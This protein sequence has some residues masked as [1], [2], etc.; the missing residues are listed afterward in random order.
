MLGF[1]LLGQ[2]QEQTRIFRW[3]WLARTA[4]R[5]HKRAAAR[6]VLTETVIEPYVPGA[7]IVTLPP[8]RPAT[9]KAE[10]GGQD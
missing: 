9:K 10:G 8:P 2:W 1:A 6:D 5:R 3:K 7:N 4:A